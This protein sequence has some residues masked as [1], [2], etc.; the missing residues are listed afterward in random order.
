M[1]KVGILSV[2]PGEKGAVIP[3]KGS[4]RIYIP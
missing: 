1:S 2:A 3:V 4:V